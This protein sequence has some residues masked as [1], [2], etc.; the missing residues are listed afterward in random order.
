MILVALIKLHAFP[1]FP[2]NRIPGSLPRILAS[3]FRYTMEVTVELGIDAAAELRCEFCNQSFPSKTQLFRHLPSHGVETKSTLLSKVVLLVGWI[4]KMTDFADS[5]VNEQAISDMRIIDTTGLEVEEAIFAAIN[6]IEGD[7]SANAER[8]KGFSRASGCAQRTSLL[9]S[10]EPTTHSL[11]DT[12]CCNVR[13]LRD[14]VTKESWL[15]TLNSH[16]PEHIKVHECYFLE[17]QAARELH[18]ETDCTQRRFEV[19]L[20]LRTLMPRD[21]IQAPTEPI[22]RR[23]R[24]RVEDMPTVEKN[25]NMDSRFPADSE[26]GQ[27]RINYFRKLKGI[28]KI[29]A[30]KRRYHNFVTAGATPSEVCVV[31][32]LDRVYHKEIVSIDGEEWV[33][34][35]VS[36]DSLLRGQVRK[37]LGLAI[38]LG[39]NLLPMEYLEATLDKDLVLEVPAIPGWSVYVAECR[40]AN[41]EAKYTDS[42]I[43]PRRLETPVTNESMEKWQQRIHQHIVALHRSRGDSWMQELRQSAQPLYQRY[44]TLR[45]LFS[46]DLATLQAAYVAKFGDLQ[47]LKVHSDE[48]IAAAAAA[49]ATVETAA[50]VPS[51]MDEADDSPA[52]E[53]SPIEI[54]DNGTTSTATKR[55][56]MKKKREPRKKSKTENSD[57]VPTCAVAGRIDAEV[58][59]QKTLQLSYVQITAQDD[60]PLVYRRVLQLLREADR[61]G[62]WPS[63]STGRQQVIDADTL[64][65]NGGRGG[66]FSVGALPKRMPQPR[67][68]ELFPELLRACFQLERALLP[69]RPPSATIAI[70]RHAQFLPHRDTGAGAGQSLSLIV[71]LGNF[72]GGEIIVDNHVHDIRY[73]PLTFDGWQ[74][75]HQTLPFVGERYSLVW[76]TPLGLGLDD[77]WWWKESSTA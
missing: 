66:S 9:F 58:F 45:S 12:F 62:Q 56:P 71:A 51:K 61:S 19:L 15:Q 40:Y 67:G 18:A 77:M 36:G 44:Q 54:E 41:W 26:E 21:L 47:L 55:K 1:H 49:V 39:L 24:H 74:S 11:C 75:I 16:L 2:T 29:L 64:V 33:V 50:E 13:P 20:P 57:A 69:D 73:A 68:N 70:N 14:G 30:G 10:A 53:D 76:F 25:G 5:W 7:S 23:N 31:R 60:C 6:K 22:V 35:S 63:S 43:D 59:R 37:L 42:H 46:R 3:S 17:S 28:F 4:S 8:P 65:E 27:L 32:K 34:L 72:T 38:L 52:I 48:E